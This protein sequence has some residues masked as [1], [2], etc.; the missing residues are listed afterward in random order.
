MDPETHVLLVNLEYSPEETGHILY[1]IPA[2]REDDAC[3]AVQ[4][5]Y[6]RWHQPQETRGIEEII[7]E[8]LLKIQINPVILPYEVVNLMM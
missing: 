3:R 8:M 5:A 6:Q 7:D 1:A 2:N 4:E